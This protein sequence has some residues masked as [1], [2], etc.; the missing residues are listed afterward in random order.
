[1]DF[2]G[3]G[4]H[5]GQLQTSGLPRRLRLLAM[6]A[7]FDTIREFYFKAGIIFNLEFFSNLLVSLSCPSY[8][9]M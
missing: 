7:F 4:K 3:G 5:R 2:G 1:V 9:S 8:I 6:T